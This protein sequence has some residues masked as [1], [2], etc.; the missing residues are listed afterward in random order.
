MMIAVRNGIGRWVRSGLPAAIALGVFVGRADGVPPDLLLYSGDPVP[1]N[2]ERMYAGGLDY[3]VRSQTDSGCWADSNGSQP[4]VCGLV[5]LAMLAKGDDPDTGPY[6]AQIG[7]AIGFILSCA[8]QSTG[9][10]GSTMYNHGFAAL[11]L[12]EAYG[13]VDNPR[14]GPALRQAVDLILS[15]QKRNPHGGWR[16]DPQR[17]DFDLTV[18]GAQF[19]ALMAARNAGIAVPEEAVQRAL[20]LFRRNQNPS[21]GFGY[22][23]PSGVTPPCSA[24][25]TLVFALVKQRKSR[26]FKSGLRYLEQT[27][28][29]SDSRPFYYRYYAAQAIFQGDA[30]LWRKWNIENAAALESLQ[31]NDGRW[32]GSNGDT[33]STAAA[34]LSLALN[35]RYLPIYER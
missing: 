33:F 1:D 22:T 29:V 8:D 34:L 30:G 25:G 21:G 35:Y 12:A 14:I 26:E 3:L 13:V 17:N 15:S 23:N 32:T 31:Q 9:Y 6:S 28:N 16:Y 11:A 20:D 10:I 27:G 7:K 5:V 19:V 4:G 24:I 18:S 2:V